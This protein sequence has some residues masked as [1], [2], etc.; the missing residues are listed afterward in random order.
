MPW[1]I[2]LTTP[3]ME[4]HTAK[5]LPVGPGWRYEPKWDGFRCLVFRDGAELAMRSKS[6][7]PLERYFPD[8]VQSLGAAPVA[9]FV[10]DG[11]IV[12]PVGDTT[13]FEELQMR[14]HPAASRVAKLAAAHPARLIAFDL[15]VD[16][17]GQDLRTLPLQ[18]RRAALEHLMPRLQHGSADLSEQTADLATAE[19]WLNRVAPGRDGVMAKQWDAPYAAGQRGAM[20]KVKLARTADCVV[21]G[22]RRLKTGEGVGS[23]LLGLY[24]DAGLLDHVGFTSNI[25]RAERAAWTARLEAL[26][27]PPG[28]TGRAPGGP[29]RWSTGESNAWLPLRPELVVEVGFDH[30]SGQ[31][32]RHGTS[33]IRV[34][35]D[36]EPR[37]CGM[38]QIAPAL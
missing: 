21:G 9:R 3:P 18:R 1:P 12:I 14:L 15:L 4:A 28:F 32:F 26:R 11:E 5:T 33:L 22:F 23:L 36:K 35:P 38:E 24:T 13:S 29:S 17:R 16:E 25:P 6:G 8:L 7:Q 20:V 19:R 31:R 30:V 27:G 34:R 2:D 37:Q 10:L